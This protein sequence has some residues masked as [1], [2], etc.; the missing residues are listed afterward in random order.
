[1]NDIRRQLLQKK[2]NAFGVKKISSLKD[3]RKR[4]KPTTPKVYKEP[5]NMNI[6]QPNLEKS[7]IDLKLGE[8]VIITSSFNDPDHN[9]II[10]ITD[11]NKIIDCYTVEYINGTTTK[12]TA[13]EN[14]KGVITLSMS[15]EL[16]HCDLKLEYPI[17]TGTF[18]L[19]EWLNLSDDFKDLSVTSFMLDEKEQLKESV[20]WEVLNL[21]FVTPTNKICKYDYG[22]MINRAICGSKISSHLDPD[23]VKYESECIQKFSWPSSIKWKIS[24]SSK[25]FKMEIDSDNLEEIEEDNPTSKIIEWDGVFG[26][27]ESIWVRINGEKESKQYKGSWCDVVE[28]I[29]GDKCDVFHHGLIYPEKLNFTF[30]LRQGDLSYLFTNAVNIH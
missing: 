21:Y 9:R 12:I 7:Y 3:D 2:S 11:D 29:V 23:F 5:E 27:W 30:C 26:V 10:K 8:N 13:K 15:I 18:R 6:I 14:I 22:E 4:P 17:K 28:K 20:N 24:V 1:M 25:E 19:P 16:S